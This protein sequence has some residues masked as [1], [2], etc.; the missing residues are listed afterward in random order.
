MYHSYE[1]SILG[2]SHPLCSSRHRP[3]QIGK[4]LYIQQDGAPN[5]IKIDD[6]T[7]QQFA[8]QDGWKIKLGNQ[9]ANSPETNVQ[10]LTLFQALQSDFYKR[11]YF[12]SVEN[13]IKEV[14]AAYWEF[15]TR[16]IEKAFLTLVSVCDE[17]ICCHRGIDYKIPHMGK[18]AILCETNRLPLHE[19]I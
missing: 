2:V 12:R 7:F 19:C 16:Q 13:L 3:D 5:H 18:Y 4:S 14:E 15:E 9:S 6:P 10:D 1:E 8:S 11:S 17:I